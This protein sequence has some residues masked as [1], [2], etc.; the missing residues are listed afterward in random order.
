MN[1]NYVIRSRYVLDTFTLQPSYST[2]C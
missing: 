1:C 2:I